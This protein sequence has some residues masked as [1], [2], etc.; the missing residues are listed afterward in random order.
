[1]I[2]VESRHSVSRFSVNLI[3]LQAG[4]PA[5]SICPGEVCSRRSWLSLALFVRSTSFWP[6]GKL[7][8][9]DP[10]QAFEPFARAF[11][12]QAGGHAVDGE[13][14]SFW[15]DGAAVHANEFFGTLYQFIQRQHLLNSIL[16]VYVGCVAI[17]IFQPYRSSL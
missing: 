2:R 17:R 15:R 10:R 7:D 5:P 9:L 14:R 16:Q 12:V 11:V 8:E 6:L 13:L 4:V 3:F 1:M